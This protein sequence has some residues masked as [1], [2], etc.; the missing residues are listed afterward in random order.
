MPDLRSELEKVIHAW[1][2]PAQTETND[3]PEITHNT[4][5]TS[6]QP[7]YSEILFNFVRDNPGLTTREIE[8]RVSEVPRGSISSLLAQMSRR[9][10]LTKTGG[11]NE[12]GYNGTY[13][14]GAEKYMSPAE[15]LGVGRNRRMSKGKKKRLTSTKKQVAPV[16][17][18][19][20]FTP[21]PAAPQPPAMRAAFD[22]D[23]ESLTIGEAR[24][25]RDKLNALFSA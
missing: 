20:L 14:I 24:A 12:L 11:T 1:E 4:M 19:D 25:L 5:K 7:T 8:A 23:V 9:H 3:Q 13:S 21:P 16:Q 22:F 10:L 17:Q 18:R 6:N 15:Q 2:T